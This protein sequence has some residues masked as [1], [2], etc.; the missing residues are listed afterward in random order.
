MGIWIRSQNKKHLLLTSDIMLISPKLL[1]DEMNIWPKTV[2]IEYNPEKYIIKCDHTVFGEFTTEEQA[3]QV[4]EEITKL[5]SPKMIIKFNSIL[6][7]EDLKKYEE[8]SERIVLNHN[9]NLEY[10]STEKFYQIPED[11]NEVKK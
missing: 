10:I 11:N 8:M 7:D 4:I 2:P 1:T 3:M 6:K 9:Q 5:I